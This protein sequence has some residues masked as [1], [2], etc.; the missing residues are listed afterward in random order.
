MITVFIVPRYTSH[1]HCEGHTVWIHTRV[2]WVRLTSYL[3]IDAG[4]VSDDGR[5]SSRGHDI[6]L[7]HILLNLIIIEYS[8][9]FSIILMGYQQAYVM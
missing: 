2:G 3:P 5:S 4:L 7:T 1:R 9:E 6:F 8:F